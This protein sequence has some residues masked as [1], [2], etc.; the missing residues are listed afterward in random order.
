[1]NFCVPLIQPFVFGYCVIVPKKSSVGM[2]VSG[3]PIIKS[4]SK[5]FAFPST[6]SIVWIKQFSE[7]KNL[8][9]PALTSFL[10]RELKNIIIASAAAVPSSN[11]DAFASSNPVKSSTIV[12]KFNNAS[13]LPCEISA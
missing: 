9:L 5:L 13:N 12:W 6:T 2:K 4:M 7:I 8:F 1:M 3:F 11:K 10:E